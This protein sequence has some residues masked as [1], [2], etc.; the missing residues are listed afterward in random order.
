[1]IPLM[2]PGWNQAVTTK[3]DS[4]QIT[5]FLPR[6]REEEKKGRGGSQ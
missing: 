1:M 3:E 5:P 6:R 2:I 4:N